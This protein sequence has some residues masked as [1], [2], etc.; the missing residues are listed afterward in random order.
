MDLLAVALLLLLVLVSWLLGISEQPDFLSER[1]L[2]AFR[3]GASIY[4]GTFLLGNNWDYRL[5]F[6]VLVSLNWWNGCVPPK[7]HS[8]IASWLSLILVLF[9][10]WHFWIMEIASLCSIFVSVDD[11]E[12]V[13]DHSR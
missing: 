3:M 11:S 4:V 12:K 6:L 13:L 10:C 9:S 5:A 1:N 2:A 8:V 7:E